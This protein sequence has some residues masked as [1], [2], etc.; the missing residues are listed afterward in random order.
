MPTANDIINPAL[1]LLGVTTQ[2]ESPSSSE[3]ADARAALNAMLNNWSTERLNVFYVYNFTGSISN[4]TNNY[5]IAAAGT[6]ATAR[7]VRI[8]AANVIVSSITHPL[9]IITVSEWA[10]IKEKGASSTIALKLY[11]DQNSPTGKVYL[12]PTPSAS[13]TIDLWL[14][15]AL[16]EFADLVTEYNFGTGYTRAMIYNLAVEVASMFGANLRPEIVEIANQSKAAIRMLNAAEPGA[17]PPGGQIN[18][19]APMPQAGA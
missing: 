5:T 7:P 6:W 18:A 13:A 12:W 19:V 4:G 1:K 15:S 11:Y 17:P 10:A 14:Y 9:E 16:P 8:E 2:G 3:S